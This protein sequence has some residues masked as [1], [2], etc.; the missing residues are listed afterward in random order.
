MPRAFRS[1]TRARGAIAPAL[2]TACAF[3]AA[4]ASCV[5]VPPA[6]PPQAPA[7]GPIIVQDSVQPPAN[8]YLTALPPEG[9]FVVPVKVFDPN[10]PINCNVFVDF[11]PGLVNSTGTA[12]TCEPTLPAL[13]GGLTNLTFGISA[14]SGLF[15]PTV[16]HTIQCFVADTF[17]R[18]SAH[19]PGDS[20]LG[21]DSVT[22]QYTPNGPGNCQQFDGGDGASPVDAPTDGLPLT[23]DVVGPP[24]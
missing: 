19:T 12:T 2:A 24:L 15:D 1:S 17:D 7:Q 14:T 3:A 10:R 22:W 6:D 18:N 9:G 13:D 11:D 21:A 8:Q 5:T 23:P 4:I 20:L 16:C